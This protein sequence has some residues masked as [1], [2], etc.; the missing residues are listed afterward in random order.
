MATKTIIILTQNFKTLIY[1]DMGQGESTAHIVRF[2]LT[3]AKIILFIVRD[4]NEKCLF[5]QVKQTDGAVLLIL[6]M[7]SLTILSS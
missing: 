5:L 6:I 3:F 4:R 7:E 1:V 2:K